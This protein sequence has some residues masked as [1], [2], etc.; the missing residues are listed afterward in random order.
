[1]TTIRIG[2]YEY[3]KKS[4]DKIRVRYVGGKKVK[5]RPLNELWGIEIRDYSYMF[6]GSS[7][8]ELDLGILNLGEVENAKGMCEGCKE[9]EVVRNDVEL[10]LRRVKDISGLFKGCEGLKEVRLKNIKTRG[11]K[12]MSGMFKG[13]K[14]LKV[15]ELGIEADKVEDM[16]EMFRECKELEKVEMKGIGVVEV[17]RMEGMFKGCESIEEIEIASEKG[18]RKAKKKVELKGLYEG[19][20][21][22]RSVDLNYLE[23]VVVTNIEGMF[24]GCE[25]LKEVDLVHIKGVKGEK[26]EVKGLLGECYNLRSVRL[27]KELYGSIKEIIETSKGIR[28]LEIVDMEEQIKKECSMEEIR[29]L[30]EKREE[31]R[32][33]K[34]MSKNN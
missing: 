26:I 12:N 10:E 19:C 18:I 2:A 7:I 21:A 3:R 25:K 1:M 4:K 34:R 23:G 31:I 29:S 11:L 32:R 14:V 33:L 22:L 8:K 9:L 20:K 30:L 15:V 5:E 27:G 13:C 16:G 6:K 28:D 24:K 17:R